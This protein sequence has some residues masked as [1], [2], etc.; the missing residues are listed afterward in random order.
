M[1]KAPWVVA[2]LMLLIWTVAGIA[3]TPAEKAEIEAALQALDNGQ[4]I[5][6]QQKQL[7]QREGIVPGTRSSNLDE[8]G[9]PDDYGYAYIDSQE[10]DGPT[11]DWVDITTSGTEITGFIDD[12]RVGPIA[13][14]D[15]S[16]NFYGETYSEFWVE[17]N[18]AIKFSSDYF[19][20]GN[21]QI[22][23][24]YDYPFIAWFWDDMDPAGTATSQC[25]YEETTFGGQDAL[26]ISFIDWNEYPDSS[27]GM[28]T[29]QVIFLADGGVV[30]Q[31]ESLEGDIDIAGCT[32]GIQGDGDTGL[33]YLYNGTPEGL[34]MAE[35]AI[36][37]YLLEED[38]TVQGFVSDDATGDPIE[39]A[40]VTAGGGSGTTDA[41]GWFQFDAYSGPTALTAAADGYF[42]YSQDVTLAE[43][44]NNYNIDLEPVPEPDFSTDFEADDGGFEVVYQESV[45]DT[46][47]WGDVVLEPDAANSGTKVWGVNLDGDYE[48][49]ADDILAYPVPFTVTNAGAFAT[50]YHWVHYEFGY[51]GYCVVVSTDGGTTWETVDLDQYNDDYVSGLGTAGFTGSA[52]VWEEV[53]VPLGAWDGQ[54]IMM[55]FRHASDFS[56][57]SYSGVSIDDVAMTGIAGP[58]AIAGTV[59][60][61]D[62]GDPIEGVEVS[63]FQDDELV[64]M[65][66][67]GADGMYELSPLAPGFYDVE[68]ETFG[69][70]FESFSNV[71]VTA[72][73][74]NTLDVSLAPVT[75]MTRVYGTVMSMDTPDTPVGSTIVRIL[76]GTADMSTTTDENGEFDFGAENMVL[77]GDY[78]IQ[79]NYTQPGVN[80]FHDEYYDVTLELNNPSI[81]LELPE[82]LPPTNPTF[83]ADDGSFTVMWD[84]PLNH[85]GDLDNLRFRINM[86][87]NQ[88]AGI[89]SGEKR[90]E[91]LADL[92]AELAHLEAVLSHYEN[93]GSGELDELP[94]DFLGYRLRVEGELLPDIFPNESASVTGLMNGRLYEAEVAADYG[95]GEATLVFSDVVSG[96]PLPAGYEVSTGTFEWVEIR[97]NDL[98][99]HPLLGDDSATNLFD[100]GMTFNFYGDAYDQINIGANG[101]SSFTYSSTYFSFVNQVIPNTATPN[102]GVHPFWDDF[103]CDNSDDYGVWHYYDEDENDFIVTWYTSPYPSPPLD[104]F[105]EFQMI[106]DGDTGAIKFQ[107]NESENPWS[108]FT[109]T[110]GIENADG[111]EAVTID[112]ATITD[113]SA[114]VISVPEVEWQAFVGTIT[115]TWT[116]NGVAGAHVMVTDQ[117]GYITEVTSDMNGEYVVLVDPDAGPYD[118]EVTA[119]GYS[120]YSATGLTTGD[121]FETVYDFDMDPW[122]SI[123]GTVTGSEAGNPAIE[124]VF[125]TVTDD[126]D[127][128]WTATTDAD[129]YYEITREIEDFSGDRTFTVEGGIGPYEPYNSDPFSF[130]EG[131]FGVVHDFMMDPLSPESPPLIT[132]ID[133]EFDNGVNVSL[134][135]PS[136]F[137]GQ[138]ETFPIYQDDVPDNFLTW[139]T[140]LTEDWHLGGI[141]DIIPTSQDVTVLSVDIRMKDLDDGFPGWP[142]GTIDPVIFNVW[143]DAGDG[144]PGDIVWESEQMMIEEG[145][146]WLTIEPGVTTTPIFFVT[147]HHP[148]PI[149]G[150][151]GI[152]LDEAPTAPGRVWGISTGDWTILGPTTY[153][154]PFIAPTVQYLPDG[155]ADMVTG[156]FNM[157]APEGSLPDLS[158]KESTAYD[159][160]TAPM[161][162]FAD[163]PYVP[164]HSEI[165]FVDELDEVLSYN[166]QYSTDE[167]TTWEDANTEPIDPEEGIPF[168]AEIGS[169]YE[170]MDIQIRANAWVEDPEG[171]EDILSNWSNP[172]TV[173][174][175]MAPAMVDD[176]SW[177]AEELD[178]TLTWAAPTTNADGTDLVDLESY[179]I[180]QEVDGE[181]V[182]LGTTTDLNY[183]WEAPE[184]YQSYVLAVTAR[185]EVPNHSVP[186]V[187]EVL[188]GT[189]YLFDDFEEDVGPWDMT[190]DG[191]W[192]WGEVTLNPSNANSGLSAWGAPLNASSYNNN[193]YDRL[194]GQVEIMVTDPNAF[195]A[196]SHWFYYETGWDGYNVQVS[197]DMGETWEVIHPVG[198]YPD[199]SVVGLDSEPGFTSNGQQWSQ[200]RFPL[201]DYVGQVIQISWVHGTDGSVTGYYGVTIDD[202]GVWGAG[203]PAYG[204]ISGT[205]VHDCD[206]NPIE[207]VRVWLMGT[208]IETFT[209]ANGDF[210]IEEVPVGFFDIEMSH[211]FYWTHM[212]ED[213]E[214]VEDETLEI[215]DVEMTNPEA[216]T[217]VTTLEMT[218][219][220]DG[221][222]PWVSEGSFMIDNVGCGP[223]EWDTDLNVLST[224]WDDMTARREGGGMSF[225]EYFDNMERVEYNE[226]ETNPSQN[227]PVNT[228]WATRG[229]LD[230]LWDPI[231]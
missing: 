172:E 67:T 88:V 30:M 75:D 183:T 97:T 82:V 41:T 111:T 171:G 219:Y 66:T 80:G 162:R 70:E 29:A 53:T 173:S 119:D 37:Y 142:D 27:P 228:G 45:T 58:G 195:L 86:L 215:N 127:N 71:Q 36:S 129:G 118:M 3:A 5:T 159:V 105:A 209:D 9:G 229:E 8:F 60:D 62:T 189:A 11:Y 44:T 116:E 61:S 99:T 39:G 141:V 207:G 196:F 110:V 106:L 165:P 230:D 21:Q 201:G 101:G 143:N 199:D 92:R 208:P 138:V 154:D 202:A 7:L 87:R 78:E 51:D 227:G 19:S 96:R 15:F 20:L 4:N 224:P 47:E 90:N 68:F 54:S 231:I 190:S 14:T 166:V 69:Y 28:V 77:L 157:T 56:V 134:A 2:V 185:D 200:I 125:I 187:R 152:A 25:F 221:E 163:I 98:G 108:G 133:T 124:G 194:T 184:L 42:D 213:M 186:S 197:A 55:G 135:P 34:P 83:T 161:D 193:S 120:D 22:P 18:G 64:T 226:S 176:L 150:R 178:I 130:P 6:L 174:F 59:T 91:G 153:G 50:Y 212:M 128:Q 85:P 218:V 146:P 24:S 65:S 10:P 13:L 63:A 167:G 145:D 149:S 156:R 26:I 216:E 112:H 114:F 170:D 180:W 151:E 140:N 40:M 79:V 203:E 131:E 109:P 182:E 100:M 158:D 198:G 214:V 137:A 147:F 102:A 38:A 144:T 211:D 76:G 48:N 115:D 33:N 175:N 188:S 95:Y 132:G 12:N 122:G 113:E 225:E 123:S 89:E 103:D 52:G 35:L 192:E 81:D 126:L 73:E 205:N 43:G 217:S 169:D 17:S 46:W 222:N 57:N 136:G 148:A 204:S 107:F 164:R 72:G 181:F 223:V 1:R 84:P 155:G 74:V 206:G 94:E 191:D 104:Q 16:I 32:I 49:N 177:E 117:N 160:E 121:E 139:D 168:F 179:T 93:S 220:L 23:S 210:F 31:Y